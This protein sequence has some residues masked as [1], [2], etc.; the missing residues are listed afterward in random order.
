MFRKFLNSKPLSNLGCIVIVENDSSYINE[1]L[2]TIEIL[3]EFM[4]A[5]LHRFTKNYGKSCLIFYL[6]FC[7][8]L[9]L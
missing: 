6:E 9:L 7:A 4:Q 8:V 2:Y 1:L 5:K 3:L